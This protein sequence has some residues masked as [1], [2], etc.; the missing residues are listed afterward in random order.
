MSVPKKRKEV[1]RDQPT[2]IQIRWKPLELLGVL[3]FLNDNFDLWRENHQKACSD[4]IKETNINRNEQAIYTKINSMIKA[5][6]EYF[7]TGRKSNSCSAMWDDDNSKIYDLV[8]EMYDK[9]K[10][11]E[12]KE[13]EKE[14]PNCTSDG[15]DVVM[16]KYVDPFEISNFFFK[17]IKILLFYFSNTMTT[18]N[19]DVPQIPFTIDIV[20]KIYNEQIQNYDRLVEI[21]RNIIKKKNKEVRDLHE[22]ITHRQTELIELIQKAN[23]ILDELKKFTGESSKSPVM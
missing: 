8:K 23:N 14:T 20:D 11:G 16:N 7:E 18:I 21:N 22:Q 2:Q 19:I 4:A 3:T 9:T 12:K 10:G 17:F 15:D 6:E 1:H 13:S 5:L